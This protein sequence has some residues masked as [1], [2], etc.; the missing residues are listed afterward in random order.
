[1]EL[2]DFEQQFLEKII[3]ERTKTPIP[4]AFSNCYLLQKY[5]TAE[6]EREVIN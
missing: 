6:R 3:K 2:A 4:L 5:Y 1:M